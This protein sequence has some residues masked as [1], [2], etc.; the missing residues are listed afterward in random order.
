MTLL[1]K[2]FT[3]GSSWAKVWF[4]MN[5]FSIGSASR[6]LAVR[7]A[8]W[9]SQDELFECAYWIRQIVGLVLGLVWGMAPMEGVFGFI[10]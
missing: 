10:L 1:R 6:P 5:L 3:P 7:V 4:F 8:D 2:A 9:F